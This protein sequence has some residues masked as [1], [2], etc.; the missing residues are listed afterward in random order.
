MPAQMDFMA[1]LSTSAGLSEAGALAGVTAGSAGGTAGGG[2]A[3]G[4]A[5]GSSWSSRPN[6]SAARSRSERRRW[7]NRR[8]RAPTLFAPRSF[9]RASIGRFPVGFDLAFRFFENDAFPL[10]VKEFL[11]IM[12]DHSNPKCLLTILPHTF[13]QPIDMFPEFLQDAVAIFR[14]QVRDADD[15]VVERAD[16]IKL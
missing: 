9:T 5:S 3:T 6:S 13:I 10:A 14:M 16:G 7:D 15:K 1:S 11:R 12:K 8:S 4:S 2:S